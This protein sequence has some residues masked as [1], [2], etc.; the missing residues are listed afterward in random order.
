MLGREPRAGEGRRPARRVG[1]GSSRKPGRPGV[2]RV[3]GYAGFR[4]LGGGILKASG[5][6]NLNT[7]ESQTWSSGDLTLE[8]LKN[9]TTADSG[10][11]GPLNL[12]YQNLGCRDSGGSGLR[13]LDF[14][15]PWKLAVSRPR[16]G[17]SRRSR[18]PGG[19]VSV[20]AGLPGGPRP[21]TIQG[22]RRREPPWGGGARRSE[23]G[24]CPAS[25]PAPRPLPSWPPPASTPVSLLTPWFSSPPSSL[26]SPTS[27]LPP[28]FQFLL[29]RPSC[30]TLPL[31]N[32]P[33]LSSSSPPPSTCRPFLFL[34]SFP[35]CPH[36]PSSI[37]CSLPFQ[38]P[39]S[40]RSLSFP[41]HSSLPAHTL[42]PLGSTSL[43]T[44]FLPYPIPS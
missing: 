8:R 41:L 40:S 5:F 19:W 2:R 11:P 36:P 15:E 32:F 14:S 27:P 22:K 37:P 16:R 4:N 31:P 20:G 39:S 9:R 33:T 30:A 28:P 25:A 3:W 24:S 42:L 44:P 12:E 23:P 43:L 35:S 34:L 29:A 17:G 1:E 38:F 13:N 21:R 18:G 6:W 26:S 10:F 7:G